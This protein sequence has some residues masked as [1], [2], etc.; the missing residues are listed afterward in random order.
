[1]QKYSNPHHTQK[2][3]FPGIWDNQD[4]PCYENNVHSARNIQN[5]LIRE[6]ESQGLLEEYY[7]DRADNP[8]DLVRCTRNYNQDDKEHTP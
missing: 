1:M 6:K 8:E 7:Q 4:S 5:D 2:Q 3:H